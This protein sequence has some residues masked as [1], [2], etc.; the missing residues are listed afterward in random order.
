MQRQRKII[1]VNP[2][3]SV[4]QLMSVNNTAIHVADW[5]KDKSSLQTI[6]RRVFIEEQ[7]VPEALE[8]DEYD[9][10]STH[11]LVT[12]GQSEIA[13]ARLKPDGQIG[14]MAVLPQYRQRGIGAALLT[15]VLQ[16]ARESGF[17]QCY[18]HAQTSAIAFYEKQGFTAQGDVFYEADIPHRLMTLKLTEK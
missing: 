13:T 2:I 7:Q 15:F 6:R 17:G 12:L 9:S 18:L 1:P 5:K 16:Y 11:F 10:T 3:D 8:W 4:F 14:R